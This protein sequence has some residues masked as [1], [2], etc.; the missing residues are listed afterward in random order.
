MNNKKGFTLIELIVVIAILGILAAIAIPRLSGFQ[1]QAETRS[2]EL[3]VET[4]NKAIGMYCAGQNVT[5][6]VGATDGTNTIADGDG[7]AE[8]IAV[9]IDSDLLEA[10]TTM[11]DT[12]GWTYSAANN[13]VE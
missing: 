10:D 8:V 7:V 9:L 5:T 2:D 6:F 1:D 11:N 4:I 12:T 13:Q 3:T